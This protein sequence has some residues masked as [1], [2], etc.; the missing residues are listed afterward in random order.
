VA[1]DLVGE[2][3]SYGGDPANLVHSGTIICHIEHCSGVNESS[4]SDF[5]EVPGF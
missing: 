3:E 2:L 4:F 1:R 5:F